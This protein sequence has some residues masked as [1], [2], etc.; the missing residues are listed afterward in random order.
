MSDD[1]SRPSYQM[2]SPRGP[3]Q[4]TPMNPY[5]SAWAEEA[6]PEIDVMEY[7]R[8]VW[9]KK[10]L[11]LGVLLTTVVFATAWSMTRPKLYR[12]STKI[13]LQ[14]PPQISGNQF[15]NAMNTKP[16]EHIT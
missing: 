2:T 6:E 12:V 11:V 10:W 5:G 14:A 4:P 8:L 1:Q 15:D 3:A 16:G 9:A 13:T 7:V